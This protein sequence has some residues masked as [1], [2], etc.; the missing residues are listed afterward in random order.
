MY[1]LEYTRQTHYLQYNTVAINYNRWVTDT[2]YRRNLA[3]R[4]GV[5]FTDEGFDDVH[6]Y[7]GGSSFDGFMYQHH[8]SEMRTHA[9]W[10]SFT[11][12]PFF[13]DYFKNPLLL[14]L[15]RTIFTENAVPQELPY[16]F[17]AFTLGLSRT[18][19]LFLILMNHIVAYYQFS[20]V[21]LGKIS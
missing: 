6:W 16:H 18:R 10:Q 2:M 20:K 9:R 8:A 17:S 5:V 11:Q 19:Y 3:H 1:A 7:G 14:H 15:T 21:L 12:Q 13:W 4:L